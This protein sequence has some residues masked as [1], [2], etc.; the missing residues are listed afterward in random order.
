MSSENSTIWTTTDYQGRLVWLSQE[1]LNHARTKHSELDKLSDLSGTLKDVV[2]NPE[3]VVESAKHANTEVFHKQ[4]ATEGT[5]QS[6][7]L[8]LVVP[9]RFDNN[10]GTVLTAYTTYNAKDGRLVY[11]LMRK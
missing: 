3:L 7:G 1:Q 5:S 9:I 10:Q 8:W 4:Y 6:S 2:E 11:T